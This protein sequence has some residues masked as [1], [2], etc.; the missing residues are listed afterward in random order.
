MKELTQKVIPTKRNL[1]YEMILKLSGLEKRVILSEE[2]IIDEISS[3]QKYYVPFRHSF[4]QFLREFFGYIHE[5]FLSNNILDRIENKKIIQSIYDTLKKLE[6]QD[7]YLLKT[8]TKLLD[9]MNIRIQKLEKSDVIHEESKPIQDINQ[10]L[11]LLLLTLNR[12]DKNLKRFSSADT[13]TKIDEFKVLIQ[14]IRETLDSLQNSN[15][16]AENFEELNSVIKD[17]V[18]KL[19]YKKGSFSLVLIS[20]GFKEGRISSDRY[21]SLLRTKVRDEIIRATVIWTLQMYGSLTIEQ[22][23]EKS[24]IQSK[25]LVTNIISLLDRKEITMKKSDRGNYYDVIKEYPKIYRFIS[26]EM[27]ILEKHKRNLSASSKSL[28][29]SILLMTKDLLAKILKI[30]VRSDE[31]YNETVENLNNALNNLKKMLKPT[32][33]KPKVHR[34]R[35]EALQ[36]LYEMYRVKMVHEKEPY[37]VEG[38]DDKRKSQQLEKFIA[39]ILNI[40]FERGLILT[41]LKKHGPLNIQRLAQ[42]SNLNEKTIVRQI[43]RLVKN[44][45]VNVVGL[46]KNYYLYD[47]PRILTKFEKLFQD[48][49]IPFITSIQFFLSLPI[50][51]ELNVEKIKAI[52]KNLRGMSTQYLELQK[53]EL[54]PKIKA[55]IQFQGETI[56]FLSTKCLQLEEKLPSTQSKFDLTKLALIPLPHIDEQYATLMDPKYLV[57]FGEIT[58][59]IN[60]CLACG[61]CQNICPESAVN[62]TPQWD[63]PAIF[64]MSETVLNE[65]PE[66]RKKMYQLIKKL[67]IK[68]PERPI[69]L[70]KGALG[71]G[72][73]KYNPLN[74][75]ACRK[76]EEV[77][78][79]SALTFQ[80]LWNFPQ[81]LKSLLGE[82]ELRKISR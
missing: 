16:T 34:E 21:L 10:S 62:L 70:P 3:I 67:A 42:L 13:A 5:Y 14:K 79:N 1:L 15:M 23:E 30:G 31:I 43:L 45:M 39:D 4:T 6:F 44:K 69:E 71:F 51:D 50:D 49:S 81:I 73:I 25:D 24:R 58:W 48:I 9:L 41:I 27:Q 37:L 55:K 56:E 65:L 33:A 82:D 63:L 20:R 52:S 64:K 38:A 2:E 22:I 60:K 29:P 80:E 76:C 61:S 36:E 78:P 19:K 77:C 35:I 68:Q 54:E 53:L 32:D 11:D 17:L 59:D 66:N 46:E 26:K 8:Q 18:N 28:I 75:I 47:I 12:I 40:D 57:G 7:E 72:D 74:C